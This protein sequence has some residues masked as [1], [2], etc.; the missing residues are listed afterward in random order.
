LKAAA[1]AGLLALA[2]AA[3]AQ[4]GRT[5]VVLD[6]TLICTPEYGNVDV[7]ASPRG[8]PAFSTAQMES[9][10]YLAVGSGQVDQL[11]GLVV[12]RARAEKSRIGTAQGPQGVYGRAGRCFLSKKKIPLESKGLVGPPVA[13]AKSYGCSV[14]G[15]VIVRVRAVLASGATWRRANDSYFGARANVVSAQL[16][17]RS[18]R[19]GK[20]LA[21]STLGPAGKTK[22]WSAQSCL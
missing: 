9:S 8:G 11:S 18:E 3:Y 22:L 5:T 19:T 15:R 12:V 10:G 6:R 14:P 21:Y 1:V 4:A 20:P 17:A 7:M 2:L 13:W 16:A